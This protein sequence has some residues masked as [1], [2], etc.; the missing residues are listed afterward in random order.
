[1]LLNIRALKP[2]IF[3]FL[4]LASGMASIF[5]SLDNTPKKFASLLLLLS[6]YLYIISST[7]SSKVDLEK[8]I[9]SLIVFTCF[10]I[11]P[12]IIMWR[13]SLNIIPAWGIAVLSIFLICSIVKLGL[14]NVNLHRRNKYG[15]PLHFCGTGLAL[16]SSFT[17]QICNGLITI[18]SCL[19]ICILLYSKIKLKKKI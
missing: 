16:I 2:Y 1:M 3:I 13:T 5:I 18:I 14:S 17:P 15:L 4:S 12:I 10:V 8:Q 19:V 6:C 7:K 9:D 11:A